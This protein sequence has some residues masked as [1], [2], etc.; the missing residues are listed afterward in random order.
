M[1]K[2]F[3]VG[4]E[5]SK[6]ADLF[7]SLQANGITRLI[8]VRDVPISRKPG[9]SK[10]S[11]AQGLE[12]VGIGYLHLKG[13]S[14][15]NQGIYEFAGANGV[16]LAGYGQRAGVTARQLNLNYRSVPAILKVA[17]KLSGRNDKSDR[18][19]PREPKRRLLHPL[20]EGRKGQGL[21]DVPEHA[22]ICRG[23]REARGGGLPVVRLG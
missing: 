18:T 17:N 15:P 1:T 23:G 6:P 9:F 16:F 11:L 13:L 10:T 22:G 4:Y 5:G 14:D 21:G 19:A 20:Q 2:L 8:D 3:T 7:A 12:E